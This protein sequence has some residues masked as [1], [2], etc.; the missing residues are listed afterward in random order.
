MKRRNGVQDP[1]RNDPTGM[2]FYPEWAWSWP[3]NRRVL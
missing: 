3:A 2:G 1:E